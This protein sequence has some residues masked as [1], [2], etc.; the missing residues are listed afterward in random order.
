MD[1]LVNYLERAPEV[2]AALPT[3]EHFVPFVVAM[4]AAEDAKDPVTFPIT[5]FMGGTFTRRSV[6]FG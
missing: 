4:G 5:R 6:Q 2:G 3:V 1:E